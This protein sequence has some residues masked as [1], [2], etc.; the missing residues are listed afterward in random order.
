MRPFTIRFHGVGRCNNGNVSWKSNRTITVFYW[1]YI[2]F[3]LKTTRNNTEHNVFGRT[4][5]FSVR[6]KEKYAYVLHDCF[7][8]G[9][10]GLRVFMDTFR[11]RDNFP[12]FKDVVP[13]EDKTMV[14]LNTG[15]KQ[16]LLG[17]NVLLKTIFYGRVRGPAVTI[18]TLSGTVWK[19]SAL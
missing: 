3:S 6:S 8:E 5:W 11:F 16:R 12:Y 4:R 1:R 14:T 9:N 18:N 19:A 10:A 7:H 17:E 2:R 15:S 13:N